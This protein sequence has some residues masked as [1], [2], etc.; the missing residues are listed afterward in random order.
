FQ[1]NILI[2]FFEK[3]VKIAECNGESSRFYSSK[4]NTNMVIYVK[5]SRKTLNDKSLFRIFNNAVNSIPFITKHHSINL[6]IYA[7]SRSIHISDKDLIK[8]CFFDR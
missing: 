6:I 1:I 5:R 2:F 3:S 7:I 8:S 4:A